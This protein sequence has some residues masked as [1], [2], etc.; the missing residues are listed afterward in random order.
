M[1]GAEHAQKYLERGVVEVAPL[2][3]MRGRTLNNSFIILTKLRT[4][5]QN[6]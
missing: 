2:A 1:V 3:F 6:R 4:P 5:H